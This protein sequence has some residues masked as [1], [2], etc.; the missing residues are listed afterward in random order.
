MSLGLVA[1]YNNKIIM[2]TESE[3][4]S[5]DLLISKIIELQSNPLIV[6][7]VTGGLIH[8]HHVKIN[9]SSQPHLNSAFKHVCDLLNSNMTFKNQAYGLLCGFESNKPVYYRINRS[10]N[11]SLHHTRGELSLEEIGDP[12]YAKAAKIIASKKLDSGVD[13]STALVDTIESFFPADNIK[14]PV[15]IKVF[16]NY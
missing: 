1:A 10:I 4:V 7:L 8:W 2:V 15:I 11:E 3:G 6:I 14:P 9:Y 16:S 12:N 13:V 5:N